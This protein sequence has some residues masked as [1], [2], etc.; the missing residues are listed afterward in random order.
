MTQLLNLYMSSLLSPS[1][2]KTFRRFKRQEF[3]LI[4]FIIIPIITQVAI[5][6]LLSNHSL[7]RVYAIFR[8]LPMRGETT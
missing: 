2:L 1:L 4:N 6:T 8:I 3:F 5:M 7:W